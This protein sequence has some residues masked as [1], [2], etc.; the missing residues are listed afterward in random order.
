[1]GDAHEIIGIALGRKGDLEG[2]AAALR[3][4]VEADPIKES[5]HDNLGHA[6]FE[7]GD[8]KWAIAAWSQVL[9]INP[10]SSTVRL[11]LA[12]AYWK[13]QDYDNAWKQVRAALN[14]GA[15]VD[16]VFLDILK[17]DSGRSQ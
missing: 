7:K 4:A 13:L 3:Q 12:E 14:A 16:P 6:L 1:M 5:A 15:S 10:K 8:T 2:A 9:A 11:Q 17:R